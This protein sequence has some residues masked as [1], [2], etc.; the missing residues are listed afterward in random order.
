MSC[1]R[2]KRIE[3]PGSLEGTRFL[4]TQVSIVLV[5][6]PRNMAAPCLS[7]TFPS[8]FGVFVRGAAGRLLIGFL[9]CHALHM[10]QEPAVRTFRKVGRKIR[11]SSTNSLMLN[12]KKFSN[13]QGNF[14][15]LA[16][17]KTSLQSAAPVLPWKS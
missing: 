12:E 7:K 5:E 1:D 9:R 15:R 4:E 14:E 16:R 13:Y 2:R 17:R 8:R 10:T 11:I 6:N 3:P